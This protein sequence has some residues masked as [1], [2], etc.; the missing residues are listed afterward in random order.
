MFLV[1]A[2]ALVVVLAG[3]RDIGSLLGPVFLALTLAVAARP[4]GHWLRARG[5]PRWLSTVLVL[6]LL[7]VVL[8]GMLAALALAVTQLVGVLPDYAAQFT[9]LWQGVLGWL[10]DHGIHEDAITRATREVNVGTVVGVAQG[11][12]SSLTSGATGAL[13]LLLSVAFLVIDTAGIEARVKRVRAARPQLAAAVEDFTGRVRRYWLYSAL[14]G[15]VLAA[16]D[17]VALLLLGVPLALTWAVVAFICNFVPNVGFVLALIPPAILGLLI[18]G[19]WLG[20]GVVAAY[21]GISFAVQTLLLPKFMGDAVGL[22]TTTT[23]LSLVFWASIIG[24]LGALLAIPL[25][26]FVKAIIIDSTPSLRW[27]NAFIS[28]EDENAK[29]ARRRDDAEQAAASH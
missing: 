26:L 28:T 29:A 11:V 5:V 22:N 8:V 12:L 1:I 21:V 16:A 20:L 15:L 23:F 3:L 24:G 9:N 18:G 7:Y 2:A 14:F 10:A 17:Y 25:T 27:L 6:V 13:F 4:A 19:P